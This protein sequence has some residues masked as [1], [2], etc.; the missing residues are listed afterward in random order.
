M[1]AFAIDRYGGP[2]M[3]SLRDL[4][5]PEPGPGDLLVEIRAASVNPVDFKIRSGGVKVLVK[6]RFPLVLGSDVSGVVMRVGPGVTRFAP[7][8]EVFARLRKDRI[9]GFAERVLVDE[10]FAVRKPAKLTHAEA[11]SIPLVGLTAYQ[12]LIEIAKL[13]KGQRVLIHAGSG[14]VGTFAIQLARH[15]GATVATTASSRNRA[16]VEGLGA[17]EVVD[18]KTQRFEEVVA[19]CDVVFDTQGGETLERSFRIV[20]EGGAV[21]TVGGKPDAKFAKAW[22]LNPVIV[23]ALGFLMRKVTR[24]ARERRATFEYLFMRPDAEQLARIAALL[25]DGVIRPVVDRTFP[26]AQTK[27][28]LAYVESGRAVGKVVVEMT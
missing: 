26:F 22:G 8:D 11:A 28:A 4:P 2:E 20:K 27:E 19:P 18:Y 6:D 16:L 23:L 15:L 7:G 14:G 17:S 21:V 10:A 12:A 9:G 25:D 13:E 5:E 3:L 24:L 1:K